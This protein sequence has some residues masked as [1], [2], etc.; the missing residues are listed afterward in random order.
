MDHIDPVEFLE[1]QDRLSIRSE[2]AA[3]WALAQKPSVPKGWMPTPAELAR[4]AARKG[5]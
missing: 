3:N 1:N 2:A 5:K 4:A